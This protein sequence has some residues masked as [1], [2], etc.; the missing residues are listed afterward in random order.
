MKKIE[1]ILENYEEYETVL[2]DRFGR[3]F[4]D[5]LTIEQMKKIGFEL[6][7]EY[8]KEWKPKEWTEENI[9]KQL[10]EDVL[11]A[12]RKM[13][14]ERGISSELMHAVVRSWMKVLEDEELAEEL[15]YSYCDYGKQHMRDVAE[16][17]NIDISNVDY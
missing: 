9:L 17:Y 15:S 10:K 11:F 4:S 16:K 14:D 8:K 2:E 7:E 5:F 3:R 6:K 12:M 13:S 1:E